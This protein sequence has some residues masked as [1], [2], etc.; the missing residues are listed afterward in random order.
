MPITMPTVPASSK[1]LVDILKLE[2]SQFSLPNS[3]NLLG[4][5]IAAYAVSRIALH[6]LD[7]SVSASLVYGP[8]VAALLAGATFL[9]LNLYK[10]GDKATQTVIALMATGA[11]MAVASILLHFVFAVALPPPL[12]T[13]RLVRFLLFPI[14]LWVVFMF[15][16]L[17]RHAGM[18]TIP[19][20]ALAITYVIVSDFIVSTLLK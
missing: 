7:H 13:D 9:F 2:G 16:F 12:P 19:A 17:Y 4:V 6:A 3:R 11:I 14:A 8:L 10:L 1:A 15:S 18:R 20:F 5:S